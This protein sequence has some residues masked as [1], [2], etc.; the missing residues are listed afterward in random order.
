MGINTAIYSR[1]GGSLGIGFAIPASN[2]R[3]VMEQ[4]VSGGTVIRGW[5][6]VEAQEV[7]PDLADSF[8]LKNNQGAL[9][10]GVVKGG[11]AEKA[12]VQPGDVLVAVEGSTVTD[13]G[14]MLNLVA[15]L[16]PGR[17]AKLR[18]VRAQ[19]ELEISLDVGRRPQGARPRQPR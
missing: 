8:R 13:P 19:K 10:S 2:A 12:G 7:T 17:K 15:A 14:N 5:I 16:E 4:I 3:K 11:P 1:S 6:G 9:I 18:L